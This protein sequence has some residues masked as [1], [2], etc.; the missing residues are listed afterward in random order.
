[1]AVTSNSFTGN[2]S[3]TSFNFTFKW[4]QDT[5][6]DVT[7]NNVAQAVTTNYTLSGL[8]YTT[9]SGGT[10][11]FNTAPAN[12]A[13][14]RIFRVTADSDLAGGSF[15]SGSAIRAADLNENYTQVLYRAQEIGNYSVQDTGNVTLTANYT[16]SGTVSGQTP[17]TSSQFATKG[18]VDS[19]AFASGNLVVGD[20]GDITVNSASSWTIDNGVVTGAKI[21]GNTIIDTNINAS[22]AIA[23][24][25]LATISTAGKV[26]G[27]AITSGNISTSGSI[28]TTSTI[29]DGSGSVRIIPQNSQ[30][31]AYTLAASDTGKHISITTGG[32]TVPTAFSG[33]GNVVTIY[34]NSGSNQTI[35]QGASTTLRQGGTANTGNRTLAQ[36]GVATILCVASNTFIITG[37]G[38]S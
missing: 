17:T 37:S 31:S 34:N 22:A 7:I 25:K 23:D 18:Y 27:T 11:V 30:T 26:S 36:Y 29:S 10:V 2:G 13:A 15:N 14:I 19:V 8:N 9:R 4:L 33:V 6:I 20:K 35:T 24:T 12:G 28:A 32:V 38:L 3:Q 5:D 1:M 21:A 16:F